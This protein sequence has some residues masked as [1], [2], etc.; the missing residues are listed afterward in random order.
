MSVFLFF[1]NLIRKKKRKKESFWV[2]SSKEKASVSLSKLLPKYLFVLWRRVNCSKFICLKKLLDTKISTARLEQMTK[3]YETAQKSK[4][5][6]VR[7]VSS[8][9]KFQIK[10]NNCSNCICSTKDKKNINCS[11]IFLVKK[12]VYTYGRQVSCQVSC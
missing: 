10:M 4:K 2:Q 1:F 6:A 12:M 11:T 5:Y 3:I 8:R 9:C 7:V